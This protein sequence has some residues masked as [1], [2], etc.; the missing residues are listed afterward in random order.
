MYVDILDETR[1]HPEA[2]DWARKIANDALNIYEV[3]RLCDTVVIA[4]HV[5]QLIYFDA[6]ASFVA[7]IAPEHR[8]LS[9]FI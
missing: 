3:D 2:Y 6:F 8:L 4:F 1:V 9:G 7:S 5:S